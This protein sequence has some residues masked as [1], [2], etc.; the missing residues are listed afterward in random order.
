MEPRPVSGPAARKPPAAVAVVAGLTL[1]LLPQV[2]PQ[3]GKTG[4]LLG[5]RHSIT[6]SAR[7]SRAG[8]MSRPRAFAVRR[9]TRSSS[10]VGCSTGKSPGEAPLKILSIIPAALKYRF[11]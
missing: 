10:L 8:G 2:L 7:A 6:S 3:N 9:L 4:Y 11:G 5:N 1:L